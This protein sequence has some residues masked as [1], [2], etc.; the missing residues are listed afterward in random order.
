M[1]KAQLKILGIEV[2]K[3]EVYPVKRKTHDRWL[4]IPG[5]GTGFFKEKRFTTRYYISGV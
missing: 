2:P 3:V 4:S 1:L 5:L